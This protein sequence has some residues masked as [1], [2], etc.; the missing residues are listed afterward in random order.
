MRRA[1]GRAGEAV[2]KIVEVL[3]RICIRIV[4]K[5][6]SADLQSGDEVLL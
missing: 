5:S 2:S 6:D 4:D 3:N 1:G